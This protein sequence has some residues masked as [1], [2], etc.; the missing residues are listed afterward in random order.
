MLSHLT[1]SRVLGVPKKYNTRSRK[2]QRPVHPLALATAVLRAT[3]TTNGFAYS[4]ADCP[5]QPTPLNQNTRDT[6]SKPLRK[7]RHLQQYYCISS[8]MP[9]PAPYCNNIRQHNKH[10]PVTHTHLPPFPLR[11]NLR[12]GRPAPS[13]RTPPCKNITHNRSLAAG[14]LTNSH[15]TNDTFVSISPTL[16]S[17]ASCPINDMMRPPASRPPPR[18]SCH[19]H[20]KHESP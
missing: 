1:G 20:S 18:K 4:S 2:R 3:E 6:T 17:V 10:K 14:S 13:V 7:K 19:H 12:H 9:I 8:P 11:N 5:I 16:F 15:T